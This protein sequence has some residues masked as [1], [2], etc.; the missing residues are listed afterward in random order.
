MVF[1][2]PWALGTF[3]D[4][5]LSDARN[6][7]NGRIFSR[8]G[9]WAGEGLPQGVCFAMG[10]AHATGV[11]GFRPELGALRNNPFAIRQSLVSDSGATH[12]RRR[13]HAGPSRAASAEFVP[14]NIGNS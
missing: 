12:C 7:K 2:S 13:L 4:M 1:L 14:Q 6:D 8:T 5:A 9:T 3:T 11:L 10:K